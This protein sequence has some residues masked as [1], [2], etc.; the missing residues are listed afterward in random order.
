[1]SVVLAGFLDS[2]SGLFHGFVCLSHENEHHFSVDQSL[3]PGSRSD[4]ATDYTRLSWTYASSTTIGYWEIYQSTVRLVL[5]GCLVDWII[6]WLLFAQQPHSQIVVKFF[7]RNI[8]LEISGKAF[9]RFD[10]RDK[11][12]WVYDLV[13]A[14]RQ[15]PISSRESLSVTQTPY[16]RQRQLKLCYINQIPTAKVNRWVAKYVYLGGL[17]LALSTMSTMRYACV[18]PTNYCLR[19][20]SVCPRCSRHQSSLSWS[21]GWTSLLSWS[22]F[23]CLSVQGVLGIKA[24]Y[25]GVVDE[26][27]CCL[28]LF[29][30]SVCPRCSRHQSSLSWSGGWTTLLSWSLFRLSVL[31]FRVQIVQCQVF[32]TLPNKKHE[33]NV[34]VKKRHI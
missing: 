15:D 13:E 16:R 23:H 5:C 21:G 30:L 19:F 9:N 29:S 7:A 24:L 20:L 12:L 14:Q 32:C 34:L 2:Y 26:Q 17:S 8:L 27:L 25:L 4:F 3:N 11:T 6:T 10:F 28:G 31:L 22:L 18:F 1:V 33:P